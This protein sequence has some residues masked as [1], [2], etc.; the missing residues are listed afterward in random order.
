MFEQLLKRATSPWYPQTPGY[1]QQ[2]RR[3][4]A[5]RCRDREP[6]C[7]EVRQG[8]LGAA[9]A[10][11]KQ[12]EASHLELGRRGEELAHRYLEN[13]GLV[14]LAR[15]WRCRE[16][17]LDIVAT[18]GDTLVVCEVKTRAGVGYGLPA[19][20][21][22]HAKVARIRR[23]TH[24]WMSEWRLRFPAIRFDVVSVVWP[25]GGEPQLDHIEGA[26]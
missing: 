23:I 20:A 2:R 3:V 19:E 26:F 22:T 14:V 10:G 13:Q 9:M 15:N 1:P 5:P 4:L 7:R 16:G 12:A 18:D 8:G 25:P 6:S 24:Q 11:D 17:E 21:V